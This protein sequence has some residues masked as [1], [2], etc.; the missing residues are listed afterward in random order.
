MTQSNAQMV[1][2]GAATSGGLWFE[3]RGTGPDVLLIAGLSDPIEAWT[4]Q[5]DGLADRYRLLA[6]DNRGAGRSPSMPDTYSVAAMADDAADVLRTADVG[7][8]HVAG[9]SGGSAIAQEL[10]LRHPELVRS[11]VLVSTWARLDAYVRTMTDAWRWLAAAA[12]SEQAMLEAFFLWI[13]TPRAH[14]NGVVAQII[15]EALAFPHPQSPEDFV[16]QLETFITHDTF[17]RLPEI[18]VPTLVMAGEIDIATPPRFG[19]IVA[20]RIPN[21]TFDVLAGEAHQPFQESPI[22]F[23]ERVDAF[24]RRVE[25]HTKPPLRA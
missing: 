1:T 6:F 13:Y 18:T 16:R 11:L 15:E 7:A 24:W 2:H 4:A 12:P 9:F 10:A 19:R 21:A 22:D 5:L 25:G 14:E 3:Q 17:D 20:E 8:A 23:N